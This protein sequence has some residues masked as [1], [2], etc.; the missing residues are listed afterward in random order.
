MQIVCGCQALV[1]TY[2]NFQRGLALQ[3]QKGKHSSALFKGTHE[4]AHKV[5][6][7]DDTAFDDLFV[8][9]TNFN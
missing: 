2:D 5:T 6:P 4:C 1:I 9:F 3:H 7:F 8:N